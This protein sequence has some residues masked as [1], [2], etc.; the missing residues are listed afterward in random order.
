MGQEFLENIPLAK[1]ATMPRAANEP[2]CAAEKAAAEGV[3]PAGK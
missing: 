3:A 1:V 2:V